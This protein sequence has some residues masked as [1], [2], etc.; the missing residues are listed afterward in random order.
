MMIDDFCTDASPKT[1][2]Q[3]TVERICSLPE[4]GSRLSVNEAVTCGFI[5]LSALEV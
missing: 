5:L 4:V 2:S 1:L 3:L